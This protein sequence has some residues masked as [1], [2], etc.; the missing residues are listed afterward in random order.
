MQLL[1]IVR[2]SV[3]AFST[4]AIPTSMMCRRARVIDTFKRCGDA[5]K[6]SLRALVLA[7]LKKI[8][9]FSEPWKASTTWRVRDTMLVIANLLVSGKKQDAIMGTSRNFDLRKFGSF[10]LTHATSQMK[11]LLPIEA[12][13]ANVRWRYPSSEKLLTSLLFYVI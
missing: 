1:I 6:L 13:H 8:I 12:D 5:R 9:S 10:V 11:R 2:Q 3:E 4:L 7:V